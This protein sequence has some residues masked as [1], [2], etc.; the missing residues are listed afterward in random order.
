MLKKGAV[1]KWGLDEAKAYNM[2]KQVVI[3]EEMAFFDHNKTTE[4]Q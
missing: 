3:D 2:L 4:L 1:F